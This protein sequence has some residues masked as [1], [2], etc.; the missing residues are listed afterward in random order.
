[1][2][3]LPLWQHPLLVSLE[4]FSV[5]RIV[6]EKVDLPEA[7]R[8]MEGLVEAER[9]ELRKRKAEVSA[10]QLAIMAAE[11]VVDKNIEPGTG[12]IHVTHSEVRQ[13][14]AKV[15]GEQM[16]AKVY[17]KCAC[18][19]NAIFEA[20]LF[21]DDAALKMF[22]RSIKERLA[23]IG[24]LGEVKV[25]DDDRDYLDDGHPNYWSVVAKPSN[26]S[27]NGPGQGKE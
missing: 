11:I 7:R 2:S 4:R 18:V 19:F 22:E 10:E 14:Y 8:L 20:D 17:K 6:W 5:S 23:S 1:M 25:L 16:S 3:S 12:A 21:D 13:K 27:E 24:F 15:D 26:A 9:Q